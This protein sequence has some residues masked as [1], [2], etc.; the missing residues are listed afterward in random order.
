MAATATPSKTN[1]NQTQAPTTGVQD[2]PK[3]KRSPQI[4]FWRPNREGKGSMASLEYSWDK[5]CF[6]L[7]MMP[8]KPSTGEN[9]EFDQTKKIV[10]KLNANDVGEI[11]AVLSGRT[12]A[13]GKKNDQNHYS[14]LYHENATGSA[15]ITLSPTN[16]DRGGYYLGLSVSKEKTVV[17]RLSV[18]ISDG[19][20]E[21]LLVFLRKFLGE[22]FNSLPE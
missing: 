21:Q 12:V 8:Q 9:N 15:I 6:F 19:E 10:A 18:G 1:T 4:S 14:G 22:L 13:L 16:T 3:F 2:S 17:G 7:N 5:R 11:L 20:V